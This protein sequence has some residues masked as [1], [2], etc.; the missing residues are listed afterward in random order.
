MYVKVARYFELRR[1]WSL[2]PHNFGLKLYSSF[3]QLLA[4]IQHRHLDFMNFWPVLLL[5]L[6]L[7]QN[8]IIQLL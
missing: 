6:H 2:Y 1:P 3:I 7:H 4:H 5:Y 8:E